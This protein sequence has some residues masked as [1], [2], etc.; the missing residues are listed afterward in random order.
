MVV[1]ESIVFSVDN[2]GAKKLRCIHIFFGSKKSPAKLGNL[3]RIS[4]KKVKYSKNLTKKMYFGILLNSKFNS[5]RKSGHFLKFEKNK[6]LVL[7]ETK[8]I[9]G[10]RLLS[11]IAKEIK[12][13]DYEQLYSI[14]PA[15]L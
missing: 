5:R 2:S 15:I 6:V 12:Y 7:T 3:I 10:T 1:K 13:Y 11:P 9:I 4:L 14:A 8:Q